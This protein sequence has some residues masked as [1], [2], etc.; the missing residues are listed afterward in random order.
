MMRVLVAGGAT[1]LGGA[2]VEHV[3]ANGGVV[4]SV[5]DQAGPRRHN[6]LQVTCDFGDRKEVARVLPV[7]LAAGPYD[8]AILAADSGLAGRFEDTPAKA[9]R[10]TLTANAESPIVI[11]AHLM[12]NH[13]LGS[14]LCIVAT[15]SN[16]TGQP[17]AAAW[18]AAKDA[19]AGYA[20]SVRKPFAQRGV[21]VTL[22]CPGPLRDAPGLAAHVSE[23]PRGLRTE[24]A[25]LAILAGTL[26]GTRVVIPGAGAKA[27]ALAGLLFPGL[28]TRWLARRARAKSESG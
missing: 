26:A 24:D 11:A 3:L 9:C 18:V 7:I 12:R 4:V 23:K 17:G 1:G 14:H 8:M 2:L 21:T 13:A 28:V 5:D 19:L 6:L 10:R 25:A 16:Y 22:A 15:L 27:A 20:A